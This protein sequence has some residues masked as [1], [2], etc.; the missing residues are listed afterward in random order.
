MIATFKDKRT[1]AIFQG[2]VPKRVS[3]DACRAA[4]A[5]MQVLDSAKSLGDLKGVGLSLE[6]LH[7]I[8]KAST[9]SGLPGLG[10]SAFAGRTAM[11]TRW[12]S[13]ITTGRTGR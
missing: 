3:A 8:D 9:A 11:R 4:H 12:S 5:T 7:A 13:R 2:Q 10:A 1:A 6:K